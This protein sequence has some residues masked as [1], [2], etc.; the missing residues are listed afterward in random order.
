[1]A[2]WLADAGVLT[3][4]IHAV[5]AAVP[6]HVLLLAYG[7]GVGAQSVNITP[8]GL[9]VTEGALG[10]T[11]VA[12]GLRADQALAAVL[13]YRLIS[14]WLVASAGWLTFLGLRGRSAAG[15]AIDPATL[16]PDERDTAR[17]GPAGRPGG[18][19]PRVLVL[20]HGQPGSP[21]DWQ[22]LAGRLPAALRAVAVDRPGYGT[23]PLPPA[24]F[25]ANARAVLDELDSRGIQ[26]AVLVGHSYG[27]GV[28]LMMASL[29]PHRVEAVVLLAS[30][31]PGCVNGWDRLLAARG[32][33]PLCA[34][35]AWRLTPWLARARLAW[36]ARRHGRPLAPEA[37]VNWQV[38]A[39]AS[40][41]SSR[42]WRT[43]LTEQRAL[44]R[45]L[46]E[47]A[48]AVPSV[49]APV[50]LLADPEDSLVPLDTARQLA[51]VL[52]D[53]RLQ[54]V[55]GAGHHLPRR[56][57]DAVADAIVAFLSVRDPGH[58]GS[59]PA[60]SGRRSADALDLPDPDRGRDG[61]HRG[62]D[63]GPTREFPQ[64]LPPG[65]GKMEPWQAS[66]RSRSSCSTGRR[67]R[68][69]RPNCRPCAP[70]N[71]AMTTRSPADSAS[72]AGSRA[73]CSR[74]PATAATWL[75]TRS[76]CHCDRR[77]PGGAS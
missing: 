37:H 50:L 28:A 57:P 56:A 68:H 24:G 30:V 8:G 4:S 20:L 23:S 73:S 47:L 27:G 74:R 3:V 53:A 7:A 76:G 71:A 14:F 21:A 1:L 64:V 70:R 58:P 15:K 75:A 5:G 31:G 69:T 60:S 11:L 49:Q 9:G 62:R 25:A 46:D 44:V 54:L 38:W 77:R 63:S 2:N 40:R 45:E 10:L 36:T 42:L 19:G 51:Q 66:R 13:F 41:E 16:P 52:P 39:H 22:Q 65:E 35:V 6:W 48:A 61:H 18:F 29:A 12:T 59:G 43:F 17:A 67:P 32:S 34:L 55:G 33:G 26:R 72:C